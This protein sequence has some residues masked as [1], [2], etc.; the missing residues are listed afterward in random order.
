MN[1]YRK[2]ACCKR[3]RRSWRVASRSSRN[4]AVGPSARFSKVTNS[5][6]PLSPPCGLSEHWCAEIC[7]PWRLKGVCFIRYII[8]HPL[9]KSSSSLSRSLTNPALFLCLIVE[10][11]KTGDFY[12]AKIVSFL[13]P[14]GEQANFAVWK[15]MSVE[16]PRDAFS[17]SYFQIDVWCSM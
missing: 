3:I 15:H 12:A 5:D 2:A 14:Y 13:L 11:K 4:W 16:K 10:K 8:I 7:I 9:P 6:S 1:R 17:A